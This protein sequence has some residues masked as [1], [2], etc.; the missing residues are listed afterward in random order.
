MDAMKWIAIN[1]I[2]DYNCEECSDLN[3]DTMTNVI[4]ILMIIDIIL[5]Q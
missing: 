2:L 4:D 5:Y 3:A 1:C